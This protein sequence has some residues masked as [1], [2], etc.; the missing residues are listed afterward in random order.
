MTSIHRSR[1]GARRRGHR[2]ALACLIWVTTVSAVVLAHGDLHEQILV[3]SQRIQADPKNAALIFRRAELYREH[4]QWTQAATDYDHAEK[5]A[6]GLEAVNLGRGKLYLVMGKLDAARA[7]L[8]LV[9]TSRPMH[10]DALATRAQVLQSMG[11]PLAAA[12]DY[13]K[14]IANATSPEP[15]YYLG[16]AKALSDADP[17]RIDEA[18]ACLDAGIT[19][20][21][22]LPTF[23]LTAI[24]LETGR[25]DFNAALARLDDFREGQAR[26]E[27]WLERRGD[28][29]MQAGRDEDAKAEWRDAIAAVDALPPR[30][31]GTGAIIELRTR[32]TRR[33]QTRSLPPP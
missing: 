3:I 17:A 14:A 10:V 27:A 13:A 8:D 28:I 32:L 25:G 30:L 22:K 31:R 21:G 1:P 6:P 15:D 9:L 20:L 26:Q 23:F 12:D 19:R 2:L 11:E 18:I 33:L 4:E 24:D 16:R 7:Q 29:L 5:L